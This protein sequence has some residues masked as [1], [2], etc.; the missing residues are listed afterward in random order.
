MR[1]TSIVRTGGPCLV[2][3]R[4]EGGEGPLILFGT[5][6]RFN[7]WNE[8]DS[9]VEGHFMERIAPGALLGSFVRDR[10]RMKA[11]FMHGRDPNLGTKP[12]G[13]IV[14]LREDAL[15]GHYEVALLD[16]P[17]VAE[18]LP[19]LRAGLFGS[20]FRF[21]VRDQRIDARPPRSEH[22]PQALPEVTVREAQIQDLGPCTFPAA[23]G[24]SAGVK[25]LTDWFM[26]GERLAS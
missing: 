13:Q 16:A 20:S 18:L 22:N 12:L 15:G 7:E 24:T 6:T 26:F 5:M 23:A 9:P 3:E 19:G 11:V 1:T 21:R 17:Y 14:S 8:I 4:A 2:R 25:S 10:G